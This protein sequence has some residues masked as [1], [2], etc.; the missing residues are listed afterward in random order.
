MTDESP[1]KMESSEILD[2]IVRRLVSIYHP[3]RIYLFGSFARGEAGQD[4]DYDILLVMPDDSPT[5]LLKPSLAHESLWG[6]ETSV[7]IHVWPQSKFDS[8][9]HLKSSLPS[10]VLREGREL[11]AA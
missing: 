8:R 7:D 5:E 3:N 6:L 11:H 9:L 2:E 4:S 10:T 1:D